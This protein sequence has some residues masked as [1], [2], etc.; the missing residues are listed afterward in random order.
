[1]ILVNHNARNENKSAIKI[2]ASFSV[3][4]FFSFLQTVQTVLH[5]TT[6]NR[7]SQPLKKGTNSSLGWVEGHHISDASGAFCQVKV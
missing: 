5:I 2:Y 7:G 6:K 1:M 4:F 3:L